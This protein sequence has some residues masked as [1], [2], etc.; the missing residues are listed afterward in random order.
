[1]DERASCCVR[2]SYLDVDMAL[3]YELRAG[4]LKRKSAVASKREE[5]GAVSVDWHNVCTYRSFNGTTKVSQYAT[6]VSPF[7][8][9]YSLQLVGLPRIR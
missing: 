7:G 9:H 4:M 2:P 8:I 1:M 6:S 3:R 5:S